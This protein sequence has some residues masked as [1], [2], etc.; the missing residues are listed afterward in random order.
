MVVGHRHLA[1]STFAG[2]PSSRSE[3]ICSALQR[4]MNEFK[5]TINQLQIKTFTVEI[6]SVY[7]FLPTDEK[8]ALSQGFWHSIATHESHMTK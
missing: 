4:E 3:K 8:R 2:T 1:P 5:Q 7:N 6:S